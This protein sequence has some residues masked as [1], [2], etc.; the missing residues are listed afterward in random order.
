MRKIWNEHKWKLL[1]S[2]VVVLLPMLIGALLWKRLPDSMPVHW[3]ANGAADGMASKTVAVFVLPLVLLA[4]HLLCLV[5]T[6]N[7]HNKREQSG[8]AL[9]LCFWLV[10][11][12]SL[13]VSVLTFAVGQEQ[14]LDIFA[15]LRLFFALLFIVIGNLMPKVRQNRSLGIKIK[16]TLENEENWNRTHRFCGRVWVAGGILLLLTMFLP[17]SAAHPAMMAVFLLMVAAPILYSYLF[18]RRQSRAGHYEVSAAN[19]VNRRVTRVS[20]LITVLILIGVAVLMFTGNIDFLLEEKSFTVQADYFSDL[21]LDYAAV[22]SLE[23]RER[24]NPGQRIAGFGTPRLRMGRFRNDEFGNY[25]RYSYTG[26]DS[27]IVL[28]CG[29]DVLVLAAKTD[30]ETQALYAVLCEKMTP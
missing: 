1:V 28:R 19:A 25:L 10:P 16:W 9:A 8:K 24:D 15:L 21:T 17:D 22:D 7:D 26:A 11:F 2:S 6:F 13:L 4:L 14:E 27:C 20:L 29:E 23:L 3:G 12:V 30:D 18:F 5:I